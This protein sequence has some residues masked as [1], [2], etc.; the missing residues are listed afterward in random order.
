VFLAEHSRL[1]GYPRF[2]LPR[3]RRVQQADMINE[4]L[5]TVSLSACSG[6][7]Q[8]EIILDNHYKDTTESVAPR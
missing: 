8:A 6:G 1:A 7:G 4:A 2:P 5:V 3:E